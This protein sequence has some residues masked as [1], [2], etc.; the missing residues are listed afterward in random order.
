MPLGATTGPVSVV[1]PAEQ[2][3]VRLTSP[4]RRAVRARSTA[5]P[6]LS[7]LRPAI[8][9]ASLGSTL[10][11]LR[12]LRRYLQGLEGAWRLARGTGHPRRARCGDHPHGLVRHR[13]TSWA[14][15]LTGGTG[16]DIC[17]P[18]GCFAGG[19]VFNDFGGTLILFRSRASG[20]CGLVRRLP[21]ARGRRLQPGRARSRGVGRGRDLPPAAPAGISNASR[22]ARPW[23][24]GTPRVA[25]NSACAGD[26][27]GTKSNFDGAPVTIDHS[28][29][30]GNS[31]GSSGGGVW[32]AGNLTIGNSAEST[33]TRPRSSRG[34]L[35][36]CASDP[37]PQRRR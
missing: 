5:R 31:A 30:S 6:T 36:R 21:F 11:R 26:G 20:E 7:A 16:T 37:D 25:G 32:S 14:S 19:G 18:N 4:S 17:A 33:A 23:R 13:Q 28:L 8:D 10:T 35:Q 9:A 2:R 3:S 29:V 24:S 34:H 1:T 22:E 27:G 15:R 12:H